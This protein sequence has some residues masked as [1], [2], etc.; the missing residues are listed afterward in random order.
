M[1]VNRFFLLS[2]DQL[3]GRW[4]VHFWAAWEG[5]SV[6]KVISCGKLPHWTKWPRGFDFSHSKL[7]WF[8][9][10]QL[11][12]EKG[13]HILWASWK[14]LRSKKVISFVSKN[15][16]WEK[17]FL[18]KSIQFVKKSAKISNFFLGTKSA[19]VRAVR[20]KPYG[21]FWVVHAHTF[22]GRI[23]SKQNANVPPLSLPFS[24][25]KRVVSDSNKS[26]MG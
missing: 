7:H 5:I 23:G 11:K 18:I 12:K 15:A 9:P 10:L 3:L 24:G 1:L 4:N 17:N 8:Q 25:Q 16:I 20:V 14:G 19:L 2:A 21:N 13:M 26:K 6:Q 22:C